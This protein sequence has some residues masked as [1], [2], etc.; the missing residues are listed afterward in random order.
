MCIAWLVFKEHVDR[1]LLIGALSIL[2]GAVLL[3]YRELVHFNLGTLA[4]V[5]A[6]IAWGIDNNLTRA[7][8]GKSAI[9]IAAVKGIVAG[10]INLALSLGHHVAWPTAAQV[11]AALILGLFSYGLSIV[12]FVIALRKLGAAR[13]SAYFSTAP[14]LGAALAVAVPGDPITLQMV[15]AAMLM[16]LG[17]Y[18]HL[19]ERHA[20][21]HTHESLE[22][23][24]PHE[25]DLHHD[26]QHSP[27]DP[28]GEPHSHWHR[29]EPTT[30]RHSHYPD[31]H[32]RHSH[33]G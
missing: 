12:L 24:H 6:C 2:V 3:S 20:H 10:G 15:G 27:D 19:T 4:I 5:A 18:L 25:H 26:H 1:R 17:V 28:P 23:S 7:L 29:H 9:Q 14:F 21:L 8:S 31:I 16:A 11:S 13:T 32:H 22:H 33:Q 30:H